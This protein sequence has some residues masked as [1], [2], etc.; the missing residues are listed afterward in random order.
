MKWRVILIILG[1]TQPHLMPIMKVTV[2]V[3]KAAPPMLQRSGSSTGRLTQK[4]TMEKL[5]RAYLECRSP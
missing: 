2:V 5:E 1:L 3:E 4:F